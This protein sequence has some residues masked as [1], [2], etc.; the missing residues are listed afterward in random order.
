MDVLQRI[1]HLYEKLKDLISII[2]KLEPSLGSDKVLHKK[3]K[4]IRAW[5]H[6]SI[7][8]TTYLPKNKVINFIELEFYY[9]RFKNILKNEK[10][11]ML[12]LIYSFRNNK[13][14]EI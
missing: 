6:R 4:I 7:V 11:I 9:D 3:E 14:I 8:S 13:K 2:R 10:F 12:H 1:H 5:A